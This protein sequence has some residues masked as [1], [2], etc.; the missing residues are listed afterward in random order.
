VLQ[1]QL[2]KKALKKSGAKAQS[3]D[4]MEDEGEGGQG[5]KRKV[6]DQIEK[7]RGLRKKSKK[8]LKNPRV[9]H[10]QKYKKALVKRKSQVQAPLDKS[11]PYQGEITGIKPRVVK[12]TKL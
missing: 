11:K 9:K 8:E 3:L 6:T 10:K 1:Q 12:S 7:N 5:G 4:A 2:A